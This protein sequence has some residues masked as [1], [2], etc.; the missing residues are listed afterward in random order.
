[1]EFLGTLLMIGTGVFIGALGMR[2]IWLMSAEDKEGD[3]QN[4]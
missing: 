3:T 2:I 4:E 1:M